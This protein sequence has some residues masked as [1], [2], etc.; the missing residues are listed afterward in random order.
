MCFIKFFLKVIGCMEYVIKMVY[1]FIKD[2]YFFIFGYGCDEC[3]IN[4]L[5]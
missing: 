4:C 1:V 2:Y 5:K 3:I